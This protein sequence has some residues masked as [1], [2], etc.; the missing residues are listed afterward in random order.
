MKKN[1]L[2]SL[3]VS[4]LILISMVSCS[5]VNSSLLS[6]S[7]DISTSESVNE[8]KVSEGLTYSFSNFTYTATGRGTC[9]DKNIVIPQ[10]YKDK[11]VVGVAGFN[12]DDYIESVTIL[13]GA[14]GVSGFKNCVNLK[15]INIPSTVEE[16]N[17]NIGYDSTNLVN[18]NIDENN[19]NY[20]SIDGNLYS[21]DG[22]TM[23]RYCSGKL[24][25]TFA[26]YEG[27]EVVEF[28]TFYNTKLKEITF[29]PGVK[30]I[31][32]NAIDFD[33]VEKINVSSTVEVIE[34]NSIFGHCY[35]VKEINVDENNNYYSSID[36][37][38]YSK[39]KKTLIKYCGG[40]EDKVF[41][42][43]EGVEIIDKVSINDAF[44]LENINISSSVNTIKQQAIKISANSLKLKWLVIP[45][46]VVT[47]ER[48]AIDFPLN[49]PIYCEADSQPSTWND[50]WNKYAAL[51]DNVYWNGEWEYIDGIPT[52]IE[53]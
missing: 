5:N 20:K 3:N 14:L 32:V 40:K 13:D 30:T 27:V 48:I 17:G 51:G 23:L 49:I 33:G 37:N 7:N 46:N 18:I 41:N 10:Y 45:K 31:K 43:P 2:L 26:T 42:I 19:E 21:K 22:K 1:K 44:N 8:V 16:I 34:Q 47:M 15:E 28:R 12:D 35:N 29:S 36:G 39:D 38:L 24:S 52:P 6:E 50:N 9:Q 25:E 4:I 11:P 53:E